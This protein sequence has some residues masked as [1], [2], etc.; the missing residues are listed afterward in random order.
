[1]FASCVRY[2]PV[3]VFGEAFSN[4]AR[5]QCVKR[6]SINSAKVGTLTLCNAYFT[7][8]E[9]RPVCRFNLPRGAGIALLCARLYVLPV[10]DEVIPVHITAF[11]DRHA[12]ASLDVV[13][14]VQ[15]IQFALP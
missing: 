5:A 15:L 12:D 8:G 6:S 10:E 11:E 7:F 1:M 13:F 4:V 9:C 14:L 3:H 2:Q